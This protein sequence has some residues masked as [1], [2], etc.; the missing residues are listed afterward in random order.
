MSWST[1]RTCDICGQ[2]ENRYG[3]VASLY[4]EYEPGKHA[5][6]TACALVILFKA[7][8]GLASRT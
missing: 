3:A 7:L 6:G 1:Y 8:R 4:T 5:C 2:S